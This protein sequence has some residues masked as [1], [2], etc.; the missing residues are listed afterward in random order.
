VTNGLLVRG[1]TVVSPRAQRRADV[2]C[3]DGKIVEICPDLN[4]D[5]EEILDAGDAL[6]LPGVVDPHV[7]FAL[8]AAPHRTADDFDA[9]SAAALAGGVTTFIDFA[10]QHAGQTF[11]SAID[12]RLLEAVSSRA[13]YT[14]HLIVTDISEGQLQE[15]P[16]LTQ[17]GIT[18]AKV[19]STYRAAG[20][21]CDDYTI[22]R[23]MRCAA[24]LGWVVMVHCEND[25]IVEGT[26]VEFLR[27][28]KSAF[29]Y[30][31]AS[32]PPLAEVETVARVILF[33]EDSGCAAYP[34]HLSVGRS[35]E[36]I[37][38]ARQRGVTV[39]G[40]TCPQFLL[41]D[42][43]VYEDEQK[44]ARF[45][46]TPPLRTARDQEGLWRELGHEG[47]KTVGSDHCGYTL[48]QRTDY[49]DLTKVAPGIPGTETLLPLLYTHGVA[50]GRLRLED[51]VAVC[52]E[53]PA[54][55]FGLYPRKGI[56]AEG[57]DA[58]LVVYRTSGSHALR[59]DQMRSMAAYT[60][61]AGM[62]VQ[63]EIAATVLR[64]SIVFDGQNVL[65]PAANGCFV[66]CEPLDRSRLP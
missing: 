37:V 63:G 30:H 24:E 14:L 57:S 5:G 51:L 22:L 39:L 61:Y 47:L 21:F 26:R 19:Y 53:N 48:A 28:G 11:E 4:A 38:E 9:G 65:A 40:E 20:F 43:R 52:S 23:F 6:V 18:S 17:R 45:I 27:A 25:A 35:A 34:V 8:E 10:H 7:H 49:A 66:A 33:A 62:S 56:L 3:R 16:R 31:A 41:A 42:E 12:A 36:L 58:D 64:G 13:D 32:R 44:S 2:R 1:G 46:H 50:A 54:R 15:M 59:D 29:R 60:P 55:I